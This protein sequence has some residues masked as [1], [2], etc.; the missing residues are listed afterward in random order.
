MKICVYAISKNEEQ[1]V[2]RW[3]ESIKDADSIYVL[4]TG[5]TDNTVRLLEQRKVNVSIK[6]IDPWR[7]DVARNLSLELVPDDYDVCICLD[8]DEVMLPGWR[9]AIENVWNNDTT[10]LRYIYNWSLDNYDNP[11]V[12][13]YQDK[14][15]AR[16]HYRWINPVHEIL[17]YDGDN[18]LYQVTDSLVINH[19]PDNN[20]SRGSYLPLL[21]LSVKEDP[22]N[23]RNMHYLGREYMY[24]G[25]WN[26]CIDT[27]IRHLNLDNAKWLDE[28]AAS[29]RYIA[30][31]Y[32]NLGR[33]NEANMW[34]DKAISEAPYLRDGYLEK[35]LMEFSLNNWNN[36]IYL[37][38]K[39][40]EIENHDKTYINEVFSWD[41]TVYDL[42]SIAYY[43]ISDNEKALLY[44]NK[45]IELNPTCE[46]LINNKKIM[47]K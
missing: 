14:I 40:L 19:Y 18:E 35:A 8:I 17:S 20:K 46:R 3:Y 31:S 38:E 43:N 30:R 15:H 37:C 21:E 12:S 5:S 29:M 44:I 1:F 4:D 10:R 45:A 25:E 36:V 11:I 28:R 47:S 26:K 32:I 22:L 39:A 9:S 27:L 13:F 2:D 6:K 16:N 42:L 23:D 41:S 33:M 7:F 24:Y 34:Y